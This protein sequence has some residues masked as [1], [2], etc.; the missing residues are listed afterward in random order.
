MTE[1]IYHKSCWGKGKMSCCKTYWSNKTN[2]MRTMALTLLNILNVLISIKFSI[3]VIL[4][5]WGNGTGMKKTGLSGRKVWMFENLEY[6]ILRKGM[7]ITKLHMQE[8]EMRIPYFQPRLKSMMLI[9]VANL[10]IRH[11]DNI[12]NQNFKN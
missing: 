2:P 5:F 4:V 12:F 7:A 10:N 11:K 9:S 1:N 6:K 3:S 8:Q